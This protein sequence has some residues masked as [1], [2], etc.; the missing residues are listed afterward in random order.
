MGDANDVETEASKWYLRNR[1]LVGFERK[2][3]WSHTL[4]LEL[5]SGCFCGLHTK[6]KEAPV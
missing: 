3:A 6:G 2:G 5:G 1:V 4:T